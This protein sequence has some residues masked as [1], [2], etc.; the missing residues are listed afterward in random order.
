MDITLGTFLGDFL[1]DFDELLN[2]SSKIIKITV[3]P[4]LDENDKVDLQEI[5][6]TLESKQKTYN[7]IKNVQEY[8]NPFLLKPKRKTYNKS[9]GK[10]HVLPKKTHT[11]VSGGSVRAH[12]HMENDLLNSIFIFIRICVMLYIYLNTGGIQQIKYILENPLDNPITRS[13]RSFC[14]YIIRVSNSIIHDIRVAMADAILPV[15]RRVENLRHDP[16]T[17]EGRRPINVFPG[18]VNGQGR[19]SPPVA[20]TDSELTYGLELRNRQLYDYDREI[21]SCQY[22]IN[23]ILNIIQTHRQ[24]IAVLLR[25]IRVFGRQLPN[26]VQRN[27][28]QSVIDHHSDQIRNNEFRLNAEQNSLTGLLQT[29]SGIQSEI[30]NLEPPSASSELI[31]FPI[32][33]P[34]NNVVLIATPDRRELGMYNEVDSRYRDFDAS[35]QNPGQNPGS[36]GGKKTNS[37]KLKLRK[38]KSKTSRVYKK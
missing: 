27:L 37:K 21:R 10:N 19:P 23:Q 15:G 7:N 4:F 38:K 33:V 36:S 8:Y 1:G 34:E 25:P 35:I 17:V 16:I 18:D 28:R 2:N 20:I 9:S 31:A 11:K 13:Y 26:F 32:Y 24:E 12:V 29:R 5:L 3:K 30:D 14:G 22:N 6:K